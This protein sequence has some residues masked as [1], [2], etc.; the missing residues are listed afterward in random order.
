[1]Q[2]RV[3][4]ATTRSS[5]T[6]TESSHA[7]SFGDKSQAIWAKAYQSLATA[8]IRKA[9]LGEND[10]A[11]EPKSVTPK[12]MQPFGFDPA[13]RETFH[14]GL[15]TEC[16]GELAD[17]HRN[18]FSI[19]GTR[20]E[21][22]VGEELPVGRAFQKIDTPSVSRLAA[23]FCRDEYSLY[24]REVPYDPQ[25]C[26]RPSRYGVWVKKPGQRDYRRLEPGEAVRVASDCDVRLGGDGL[27]GATGLRVLIG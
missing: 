17:L 24:V 3:S 15:G 1:M 19:D 12:A 8:I 26:L 22:Q 21:P 5:P 18:T 14:F 4:S 10:Q 25:R 20:L 27:S 6:L 16:G 2:L 11:D 9:R 13:A 23:F 7:P